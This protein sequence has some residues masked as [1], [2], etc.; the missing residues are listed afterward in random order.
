M[1]LATPPTVEKPR[2]ALH[3]KA[4]EEDG[5]RSYL[6][7]DKVHRRDVLSHAYALS[8]AARGAPGV[9]GETFVGIEA[10]GSE[11]WLDELAEELRKK[12]YRAAP[13]RRVWIPKANGGRRPLG[14]PTIRDRVVQTAAVLVLDPIFEADLQPEQYAYRATGVRRMRCDTFIGW[15]RTDT[16]KWSMRTCPDTSTASR[17]RR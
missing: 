16:M 9:D 17:T 4:K 11:A 15:S 2:K 1:S 6:L 5:Y 12:A 8:R 7:Y 14:I 13:V 3:A 10:R